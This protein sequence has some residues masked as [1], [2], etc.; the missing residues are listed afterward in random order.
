MNFLRKISIS[1]KNKAFSLFEL[2]LSISLIILVT[3]AIIIPDITKESKAKQKIENLYQDVIL[4]RNLAMNGKNAYIV[5]SYYDNS[6][7]LKLDEN[8][9]G[10]KISLSPAKYRGYSNT[11]NIVEFTR[12]GNARYAGEIEVEIDS[13][14]G[15]KKYFI[16]IYP[17][18]GNVELKEGKD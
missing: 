6:Y 11:K 14:F 10:E 3:S 8:M 12:S 9:K 1:N 7:L 4:V 2:I 5:F 18:T 15:K 13:K 16:T 17:A